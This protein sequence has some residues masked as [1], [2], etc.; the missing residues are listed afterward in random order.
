MP[1]EAVGS[2]LSL[3]A[4]ANA[5][6][7]A[8][9]VVLAAGGISEAA[10]ANDEV[11]GVSMEAV[12]AG[13]TGYPIACARPNGCKVEVVSGAAVLAGALLTTDSQGRAI[14]ATTGDNVNGQA[15]TASGA[16]GEVITI[17]FQKAANVLPA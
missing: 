16:A 13:L 9:F 2:P 5:I 4:D 10:D 6:R 15:L 12:G 7:I 8:R 17:L 1:F 11:V 3:P 14:T